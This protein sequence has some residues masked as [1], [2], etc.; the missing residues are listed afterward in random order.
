MNAR[1]EGQTDVE[2]EIVIWIGT[3]LEPRMKNLG[4]IVKVE[5]SK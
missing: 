1:T 3:H 4:Q 2:S 5:L